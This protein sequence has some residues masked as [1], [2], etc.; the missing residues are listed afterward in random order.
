MNLEIK[1][2]KIRYSNIEKMTYN[3]VKSKGML[4]RVIF[5]SFCLGSLLTLREIDKNI[6][7]G[8]LFED[9]Y[10]KNKE[11]VFK[12]KFNAAH[13]KYV[14]L[15]EKEINDYLKRGIDVNTWTVNDFEI[16]DFLADEGVKVIIT[17]RDI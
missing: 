9:D 5:S 12:Y 4:N 16:K 3:L 7:L 15:N 14:F 10:I 6:Y 11:L 1:T 17:N 8:Y 2:D 13:P